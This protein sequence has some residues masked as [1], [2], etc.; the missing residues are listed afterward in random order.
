MRSDKRLVGELAGGEVDADLEVGAAQ[1]RLL[2]LANLA[3]RRAHDARVDLA[4]EP[5]FLGQ[6]HEVPR[7]DEHPVGVRP[8]HQRLEPDD[9]VG[10]QVH[11]RAG[12]ARRGLR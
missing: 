11:D 10:L 6:R 4:D 2:P 1:A 7:I 8:A 9:P 12:S 3:A 5:D